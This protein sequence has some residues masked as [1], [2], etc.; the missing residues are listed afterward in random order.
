VVGLL[1]PKGQADGSLIHAESA[2]L[3]DPE[4]IQEWLVDQLREIFHAE[5]QLVKPF[6]KMMKMMRL[7]RCY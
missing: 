2:D 7:H 4:L 5:N 6:P 1:R 3:S